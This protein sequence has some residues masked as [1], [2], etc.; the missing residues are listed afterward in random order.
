M[1]STIPRSINNNLN[2]GIIEKA[3][4]FTTDKNYYNGRDNLNAIHIN[5]NVHSTAPADCINNNGCGW[6][7]QSNTCVPGTSS[8]PL[9]PCLRNS[10]L[11]TNPPKDWNPLKASTLNIL[12]KNERGNPLNHIVPE[13]NLS[14][15]TVF[16]P[17]N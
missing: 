4:G 5:C 16:A 13:P 12:A 8:G 10:F 1:M 9:A 17:Y 3:D 6:C 14:H 2:T 11:Y 15:A 7:G